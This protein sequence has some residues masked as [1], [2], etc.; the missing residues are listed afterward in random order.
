[1]TEK[2]T[3]TIPP[4]TETEVFRVNLFYGEVKKLYGINIGL[5]N[6]I[7][8]IRL[9]F[10]LEGKRCGRQSLCNT[11]RPL[12]SIRKRVHDPNRSSE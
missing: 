10:K 6:R 5:L 8:E 7:R 11:N 2:T 3:A 1:M 4:K 9:V 12:Q